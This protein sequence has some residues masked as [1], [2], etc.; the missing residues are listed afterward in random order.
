MASSTIATDM[1]IALRDFKKRGVLCASLNT[2]ISGLTTMIRAM[3]TAANITMNSDIILSP[4][5]NSFYITT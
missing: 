1:P 5:L 2:N 4:K 3:A